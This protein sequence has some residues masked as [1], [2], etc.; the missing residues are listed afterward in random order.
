MNLSNDS[1]RLLADGMLGRL[2]RWLR[3]LGYDTV[4]APDVDNSE[5]LRR[6]RAEER[7]LLT[8]DHALA[9]RKGARTLLVDAPDLDGQLRQVRQALGP[10]PGEFTRCVACNGALQPVDKAALADQVPP[11]V[12]ATQT[13]FRRCPECGRIYWPGTHVEHMKAMLNGAA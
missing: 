1:S 4:F 11:Y 5:L 8:A 2:A 3:V 9:R 6:A 10:P 13:Q 12:L 7:V